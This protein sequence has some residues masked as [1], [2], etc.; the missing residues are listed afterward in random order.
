MRVNVQTILRSNV[1]HLLENMHRRSEE[2]APIP[3]VQSPARISQPRLRTV[4][5]LLLMVSAITAGCPRYRTGL[6]PAVRMPDLEQRTTPRGEYH[7][8]AKGE[9][10]S[11]I[12]QGFNA[13]YQYLAEVNNLKPPYSIRPGDEIFI[14]HKDEKDAFDPAD[15]G[16]F[17]A[18]L[19]GKGEERPFQWPVK[20]TVSSEFGVRHGVRYNG[21]EISAPAGSVVRAAADGRV[22]HVGSIRSY[23]KVVIL[24]HPAR[25]V[26]VYGNMAKIDVEQGRKVHQGDRLGTLAQAPGN[27]RGLL[28][29]EV[30]HRARP[31]NPLFYLE[32]QPK[33]TTATESIRFVSVESRLLK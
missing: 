5:I 17:L 21:I 29:F 20:G 8:V 18:H 6:P 25:I 22:G 1:S 30:R 9:T 26:T 28:H 33:Q 3:V 14:P 23:G 12:A 31:R 32:N 15:E 11:E 13:D 19:F 10:L 16:S 27:D 2:P 7:R 24:Q 4:F